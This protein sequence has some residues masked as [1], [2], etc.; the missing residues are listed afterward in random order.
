MY[1]GRLQFWVKLTGHKIR[2]SWKFHNLHNV[3]IGGLARK[4]KTSLLKILYIYRIYFIA[5]T[6]TLPSLA[7]FIDFF[8][9]R[10]SRI[11]TS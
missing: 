3:F 4:Y 10:S 8:R 2:M 11:T 1:Q 6:E 7:G 5:V 9:T